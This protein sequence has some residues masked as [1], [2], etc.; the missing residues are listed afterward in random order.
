MKNKEKIARLEERLV[1]LRKVR[2]E[3]LDTMVEKVEKFNKDLEK[4][5][6]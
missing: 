5:T 2:V 4:G 6:K 1:E 3:T